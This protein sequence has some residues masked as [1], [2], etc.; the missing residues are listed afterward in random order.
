M[1]KKTQAFG[2]FSDEILT[3]LV[4]VVTF[5]LQLISFATTWNGSKIYLE[6]IFPFA[7]LFFAIA[8]Q[9]TA[10]FLSNSLRNRSSL[11][12]VLAMV[13]AL[14]CSTYYSY[15]GI[16][17]SVN[18]PVSYLQEHY[19]EVADALTN[20]LREETDARTSQAKKELGDA[21]A[22]IIAEYYALTLELANT[23]ACRQALTEI[24]T[25][26]TNS[27]RA[28]S[29]SAY[30]NYEDYVADY[31]AYIAGI[32]SGSRT[33]ADAAQ[34]LLLAS[35]GYS[36]MEELN[37][38]EQ[39]ASAALQVLLSTLS[40]CAP[41]ATTDF[42]GAISL[43]QG[44]IYE[45][46]DAAALGTSP[47][48][49]QN[50]QISCFFQTA[51]LCGYEGQSALSLCADL[52]ICAKATAT[53]LLTDYQSLVAGLFE[54]QVTDS[55][56]M[57]LKAAMD[58]EIMSAILTMNSLLP[59]E[60]RLSLSDA[61]YQITD[62]YLVPITALQ[63]S[64]TR[65]T[66]LFCLSMAALVDLLSVLFAVSLK[67]K[68][69]LWERR[70]L[71]RTGFADLEPQIFASLPEELDAPAALLCFLSHFTTSP[72]TESDGYM[73]IAKTDDLQKFQVLSALLCQVNLAKAIPG[74]LLGNDGDALL[75]KARFVLWANRYICQARKETAY[76]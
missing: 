19:T 4:S 9:A 71:V 51:S 14:C 13:V 52:E 8:I 56:I 40:D 59:Q 58:S 70:F 23:T 42:Q 31:N 27:L 62:L 47:T 36:S 46:I 11:L 5:L 61:R 72:L 76:E 25:S 44:S 22:A 15:M 64:D 48:L 75:L 30:E 54:G 35:Y 65:M 29:K 41:D 63:K 10:Y 67:K 45:A 66:A 39:Q 20:Q 24:D 60:S 6:N 37:A 33:E 32:S 73:M 16:Y 26:H 55:N 69:P 57:T 43:L 53:P 50:R 38:A 1:K 74:G 12:K 34:A 3:I 49:T 18:S 68:A 7:S 21:G 17:N 2:L 28:P